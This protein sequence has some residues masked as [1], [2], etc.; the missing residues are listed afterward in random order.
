MVEVFASKLNFE[1]SQ[2]ELDRMMSAVPDWRKSE[3]ARFRNT[4][5]KIRCL[6]SYLLAAK[7]IAEKAQC[8]G[9][10]IKAE[11]GKFG[12]LELLYP[13]GWHF[14]ISHSGT[15][16][17]CAVDTDSVGIDVERIKPIDINIAK[18]FFD[19][20][21]FDYIIRQPENM[22]LDAFY[23]TWTF[24]ESY[25]KA[26]GMGFHKTLG[27]FCIKRDGG[28]VSVRDSEAQGCKWILKRL[29]FDKDY[30]LSVTGRNEARSA[31]FISEEELIK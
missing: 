14:N 29:R 7:I 30:I 28:K 15:W 19:R 11:R 1:K 6:A 23:E 3:A 22:R 26:T 12:K 5:D 27:S 13:D 31:A 18:R 16:V 10:G 2:E 25:I 20:E 24:K 17:A 9:S 4:D 21:E 8:K